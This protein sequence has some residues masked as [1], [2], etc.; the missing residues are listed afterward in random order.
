MHADQSGTSALQLG[1]LLTS[2][3]VLQTVGN[4]GKGRQILTQILFSDNPDPVYLALESAG[5]VHVNA[6]VTSHDELHDLIL[7]IAYPEPSVCRWLP[8]AQP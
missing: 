3:C 4:A 6:L 5:Q 2:P 7:S 1:S 8:P